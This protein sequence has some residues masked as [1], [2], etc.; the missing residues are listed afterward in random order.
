MSCTTVNFNKANF[1]KGTTLSPPLPMIVAR[2]SRCSPYL[3][4]ACRGIHGIVHQNYGRMCRS[5]G[6]HTSGIYREG[7]FQSAHDLGAYG[8]CRKEGRAARELMTSARAKLN[9]RGIKGNENRTMMRRDANQ[10]K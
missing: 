8:R 2:L 1:K 6:V 9:F 4:P 10:G 7:H 5:V 3:P